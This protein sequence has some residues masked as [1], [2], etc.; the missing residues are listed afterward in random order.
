M[1]K[2]DRRKAL[3]IIE[4]AIKLMEDSAPFVVDQFNK[5]AAKVV[6]SAKAEVDGFVTHVVQK[7][8]LEALAKKKLIQDS[9]IHGKKIG[10]PDV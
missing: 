6:T 10:G 9:T 1:S 8:G 4:D 3:D 2:G 5:A 7:T